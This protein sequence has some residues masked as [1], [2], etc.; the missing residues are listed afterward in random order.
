VIV[1]S[2]DGDHVI[3]RNISNVAREILGQSAW[4]FCGTV[5][6]G[7]SYRVAISSVDWDMAPGQ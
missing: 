2:I 4:Q 1:E 5:L 6:R 7:A 3:S